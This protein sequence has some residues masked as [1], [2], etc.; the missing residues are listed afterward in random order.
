MSADTPPTTARPGVKRASVVTPSPANDPKRES[1]VQ[2]FSPAE[3]AALEI[4]P[5]TN[6]LGDWNLQR[7][8]FSILA[9]PAGVGKSRADMQL[10]IQAAR[11]GGEWLGVPVHGQFRSLILQIENGA[12]RLHRTFEQMRDVAHFSDWIRISGPPKLGF[13]LTS[14]AFRA[15]LCAMMKDFAPHILH[16]DPLNG[17]LR[18][19][20]ERDVGEM[21]NYLREIMAA[22]PENPACVLVHHLRKP[23]NDDKQRGRGLV[24]LLAGS[25]QIF[26]VARS[27]MILQSASD[28]TSDRR[29]VMTTSKNNDGEL[30]PRTAW[31]WSDDSLCYV[32]VSDFNWTAYDSDGRAPKERP[33]TIEHLRIVF[34]NG[35]AFMSQNQAAEKL[36]EMDV[37]KRSA[38]CI[39]L[40]AYRD[41]GVIIYSGTMKGF[42]LADEHCTPGDDED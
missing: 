42:T 31:Q 32:P 1:L 15:E 23:K 30:S 7:G 20:Q 39:H 10:A 26:S 29:V 24:N 19:S 36:E 34:E 35:K 37:I 3:L 11:G 16:I 18:E 41:D 4:P 21:F 8:A 27:A 25:Y 40:K 5:G 38:A 9:G 6:M 12:A 14:A 13:Q 22:S 2:W 33:V 28:D 17:V